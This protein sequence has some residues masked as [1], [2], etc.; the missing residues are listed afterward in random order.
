MRKLSTLF[1]FIL[2]MAMFTSCGKENESGSRDPSSSGVSTST[3]SSG[4]QNFSSFSTLQTFY[5]NKSKA[6]NLV[7]NTVIYHTGPLFGA[8][9]QSNINVDF[10]LVFC[11]GNK[12]M[13]GDDSLCNYSNSSG[14]QLS[15]MVDNGEYKV[16]KTTSASSVNYEV[17]TGVQNNVFV[18]ADKVFDSSDSILKKMLNL[19]NKSTRKIVVS[20]ANVVMS[21]NQQLKSDLVEYFYSDGSYQ[22]HLLGSNIAVLANPIISIQGTYNEYGVSAQVIGEL[23]NIGN[24]T[25]RNIQATMHKIRYQPN[26]NTYEVLTNTQLI[27]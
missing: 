16:V 20:A 3:I 25:V 15:D 11:V 9:N 27:K 10:S 19:D 5:K 1:L 12:N 24:T 7:A 23:N 17:A 22:A 21:N 6:E 2:T 13:I 4:G 26:T 14:S 18:M 8:S